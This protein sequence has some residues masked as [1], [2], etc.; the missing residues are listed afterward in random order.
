[1]PFLLWRLNRPLRPQLPVLQSVNSGS[2]RKLSVWAFILTNDCSPTKFLR[3]RKMSASPTNSLSLAIHHPIHSTPLST[4]E[5]E[6][7]NENEIQIQVQVQVQSFNRHDA[8]TS[9]ATAIATATVTGNVGPVGKSA[10]AHL[11]RAISIR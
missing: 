8:A 3:F 11:S 9:A 5:N 7:E 2:I 6:N 10:H 1:M 4:D